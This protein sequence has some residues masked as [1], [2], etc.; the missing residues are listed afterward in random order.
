M[1]ISYLLLLIGY[2]F[3]TSEYS[4]FYDIN[5]N[6]EYVVDITRYKEGYLPKGHSYFF[7]MAVSANDKME[8]QCTVDRFAYVA[9]K[10]DICAYGY[11]P[12]EDQVETGYNGVCASN[13]EGAKS[14]Y[15]TYDR[16]TYPFSTGDNVQYLA[17]HLQNQE[18]LYYLSVYVYS[19]KGMATSILLL[20]ILLPCIIVVLVVLAILKFCCGFLGG[21]VTVRSNMI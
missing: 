9:F 21:S 1:K 11:F 15:N 16:Y 20:I 8:I 19:E 14:E 7:R 4:H 2:I 3:C 12:S 10:V 6:Q 5:Y 17:I 13:L 18:S